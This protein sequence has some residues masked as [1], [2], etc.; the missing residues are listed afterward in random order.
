MALLLSLVGAVEGL[1]LDRHSLLH[2]RSHRVEFRVPGPGTI[3]DIFRIIANRLLELFEPGLQAG[4]PLSI[5]GMLDQ[6]VHL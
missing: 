6:V 4:E 3:A 5:L 1:P 2:F